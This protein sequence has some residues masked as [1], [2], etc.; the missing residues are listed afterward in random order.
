V[1]TSIW[2][3]DKLLFN[4]NRKSGLCLHKHISHTR[5]IGKLQISGIDWFLWKLFYLYLLFLFLRFDLF[6]NRLFL[7]FGLRD[8]LFVWFKNLIEE[9]LGLS[10]FDLWV[11]VRFFNFNRLLDF[12]RVWN[13]LLDLSGNSLSF[14]KLSHFRRLFSLADR[15]L[16]CLFKQISTALN[17]GSSKD[18]ARS[19]ADLAG[20]VV[21]AERRVID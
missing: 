2:L 9:Y 5:H 1:H 3:L 4:F 15:L 8:H 13:R 20:N 12:H 10:I 11:R 17:T 16:C 7:N 18:I 6:N 14:W 21:I 19:A